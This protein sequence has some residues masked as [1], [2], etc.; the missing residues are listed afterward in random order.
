MPRYRRIIRPGDL[1]HVICRIVNHEFRITSHEERL[2]YLRRLGEAAAASGWKVLAFV[3]MSNHVHLVVVAG[4]RP[5]SDFALRVNSP[6]GNWLN[7]HQERIGPVFATRSKTIIVAPVWAPRLIAY[8]HNNP[9]RAGVVES[10][11]ESDWSS[12]R[13]YVGV[14]EAPSFLDIELGLELMGFGTDTSSRLAFDEYV[15]ERQ[16]EPRDPVLS[17][18]LRGLDEDL[19]EALGAMVCI[20][21]PSTGPDGTDLQPLV[22]V[23]R[24]QAS[25]A[26][27]VE[28]AARARGL[29]PAE[30]TS[31]SR[32]QPVVSARRVT[33]V[34]GAMIGRSNRDIGLRLGVSETAVRSLRRTASA[35]ERAEA[36]RLLEQLMSDAAE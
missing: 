12:H 15:R 13:A 19:R 28:L 33:A 35:E 17:G 31:R 34:L 1:V 7:R 24:P 8:A 5:F 25:L 6:F 2:E 29:L 20:A 3:I 21:H 11:L 26:L 16:H 4:N 14:A 27:L 36:M 9:P 22:H 32:R 10:A 18:D 23:P 30:V